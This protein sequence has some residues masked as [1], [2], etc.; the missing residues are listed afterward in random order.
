MVD[1]STMWHV[2]DHC[3][4]VPTT[5]VLHINYSPIATTR[6]AHAACNSRQYSILR[7]GYRI[8]T[9]LLLHGLDVGLSLLPSFVDPKQWSHIVHPLDET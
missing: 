4:S 2:G 9:D 3:L 8:H 1:Q 5:A 6:L 7:W